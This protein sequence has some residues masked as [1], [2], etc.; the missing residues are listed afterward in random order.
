MRDRIP[1]APTHRHRFRDADFFASLF[2]L[3]IMDAMDRIHNHL[4]SGRDARA[5]ATGKCSDLCNFVGDDDQP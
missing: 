5:G 2:R 1:L 4:N 3:S